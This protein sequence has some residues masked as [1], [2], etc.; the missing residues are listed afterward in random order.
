MLCYTWRVMHN[1]L[2]VLNDDIMLNTT[3]VKLRAD[4]FRV[5]CLF[6]EANVSM[7]AYIMHQ[8][9]WRKLKVEQ[10]V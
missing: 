3:Y 1:L 10:Q 7:V 9:V 5:W 6:Y 4:I 8:A 2:N